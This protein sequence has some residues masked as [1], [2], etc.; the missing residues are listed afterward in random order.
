MII[1]RTISI[2]NWVFLKRTEVDIRPML[3]KSQKIRLEK[4]MRDFLKTL[5]NTKGEKK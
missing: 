3:S 5:K 4:I 2:K 1:G